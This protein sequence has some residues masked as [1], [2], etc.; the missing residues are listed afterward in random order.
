MHRDQREP[1]ERRGDHGL[2]RPGDDRAQ[3][4]QRSDH[5]DR[6][7]KVRSHRRARHL[8][9]PGQPGHAGAF[10]DPAPLRDQ[11]P[12]SPGTAHPARSGRRPGA[13]QRGLHPGR[14]RRLLRHGLLHRDPARGVR[15]PSRARHLRTRPGASP[16]GSQPQPGG[17]E[18]RSRPAPR[19]APPGPL[20]RPGHPAPAGESDR[21]R[22][23]AARRTPGAGASAL[24]GR[25][26]GDRGVPRPA[27]AKPSPGGGERGGRAGA[28]SRGRPPPRGRVTPEPGS[29]RR[30]GDPGRLW[31]GRGP[32]ALRRRVRVARGT[33]ADGA[34]RLPGLQPRPDPARGSGYRG[35]QVTRLPDPRPRVGRPRWRSRSGLDPHHHLAGAVGAAR[36]SPGREGTTSAPGHGSVEGSGQL[37]QPA[38]PG[39]LVGS[40]LVRAPARSRRGA[41]QGPRFDLGLSEPGRRPGRAAPGG[42]RAGVLGEGWFHGRRLSR[43]RLSQ[44]ARR[45]LLHGQ[46]PSGGPGGGPGDRQPCPA[47]GRC[48]QRGG[49]AARVPPP[50]HRRGPSPGGSRH[51]IP[52]R[53]P[54]GGGDSGGHRPHPRFRRRRGQ[55]G[56]QGAAPGGDRRLLGAPPTGGRG[57]GQ[58]RGPGSL[59]RRSRPAGDRSRGLGADLAVGAPAG[60]VASPGEFRP[61]HRR[62]PGQRPDHHLAAAGQRRSRVLGRRR[63]PGRD[64]SGGQQFAGQSGRRCR[65]S[66]RGWERE[67]GGL[68]GGGAR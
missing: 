64:G 26:L 36:C 38:P 16:G 1:G 54:G 4:P 11:G 63:G 61:A 12:G 68:G 51:S 40:G 13:L 37:P 15:R 14:P 2:L 52:G 65:R 28:A 10:G 7:G 55:S 43:S 20:R 53:T 9:H 48:R 32:G 45:P 60:P 66:G 46:G 8:L 31:G 27:A 24:F 47:P 41:L 21:D 39:A 59:V 58:P 56:S 34:G 6:G 44:L 17:A 57:D 18:P 23:D 19:P 35:G 50:D 62:R 30:G 25:R 49:G 42:S 22:S 67:P 33:A 5:R 29:Y 3:P